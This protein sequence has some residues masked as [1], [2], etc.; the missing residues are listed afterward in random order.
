M[1]TE[2]VGGRT[3]EYQGGKHFAG[4]NHGASSGTGAAEHRCGPARG[5]AKDLPLLELPQP[6]L[7]QVVAWPEAQ[8]ARGFVARI[9]AV[10]LVGDEV[11]DLVR[12]RERGY[13]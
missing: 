1:A 11:E 9:L 6:L 3:S 7:L 10:R 8:N 4:M 2:Y 5:R 12:P 13:V